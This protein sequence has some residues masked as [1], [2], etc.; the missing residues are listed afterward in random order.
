MQWLPAILILPYVI[1]LIKI[2]RSLLKISRF[3]IDK[4]PDTFLSVV[5]A[6]R[7]E[8]KNLPSLLNDLKRQNYSERLFEVIIVDDNS[9]DKTTDVVT[10]FSGLNNIKIISNPGRGKKQA[11]RAGINAARGDLILTT[12]ADCRMKESWI[13]TVAGFYEQFSP[14]MIILPVMISQDKGFFSR[15]QE[16]E[17]LSLQGITAGAAAMGEPVMCN[18]ANLAFKKENYLSHSDSLHDEINS[19]DDI[20]LLHS[21]KKEKQSAIFWLESSNAMVLTQPVSTSQNFFKQRSRWISKSSSYNDRNTIVLGIVTFIAVA[22]QAGTLLGSLINPSFLPV[23]LM[24]F[25]LKSIPDYLI[26]ENTTQ[27]YSRKALM[28]WFFPSQLIY[29]FYVISV[30]FY[31]LIFRSE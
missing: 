30:I 22:L 31:S 2:Y 8:E 10:S 18:G 28:K 29:P 14:D 23:F 4:E 3:S 20:F 26:L 11:I 21:L 15:F 9:T 12:D 5:I 6:C 27:R 7:N 1:L 25:I 13:R 16:L 17:F 24:I 19:G